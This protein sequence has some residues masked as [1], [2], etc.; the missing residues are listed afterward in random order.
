MVRNILASL[1]FGAATLILAQNT[2]KP[3]TIVPQEQQAQLPGTLLIPKPINYGG[4][5]IA[6]D[7]AVQADMGSLY[8][9]EDSYNKEEVKLQQK[10]ASPSQAIKLKL[11]NDVALVKKVNGW[12]DDVRFDLASGHWF[13]INP[14]QSQVQPKTKTNETPSNTIKS[15]TP[16]KVQT[17]TKK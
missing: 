1:V 5:E 16:A 17:S 15:A 4:T 10:Y 6:G 3:Q 8:E 14:K 2:P 7:S 13:R 12:G 9:L 11:A